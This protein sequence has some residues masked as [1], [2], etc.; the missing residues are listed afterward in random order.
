MRRASLLLLV[1]AVLSPL[2]L[3]SPSSAATVFTLAEAPGQSPNW[4]APLVDC[5]HESYANVQ[6]F[7]QLMYRP[8]Y[9]YG[10]GAAT[11]V[12]PSMSLANTPTLSPSRTTVTFTMKGWRFATR[13]AVTGQNVIFFLNLV[14]STPAA[15]CADTPGRGI[16]D[17]LRSAVAV[18]NKVTLTFSTPV[19]LAWLEGNYLSQITPL[20]LSWSRSA[21]GVSN[22]ATSP[23]GSASAQAS[24]AGVVT[25]LQS[26]STQTSSYTSS[27]WAS[28][29]DG[30]YRLSSFDVHGNATFVPNASYSGE[31]HSHVSALREIATNS[32]GDIEAGLATNSFSWAPLTSADAGAVSRG[33][34]KY[35]LSAAKPWAI[36]FVT[37]NANASTKG[38]E[39][40]QAYIRQAL[41]QA[42]DQSTLLASA[43][44]GYGVVNTAP[45]PRVTPAS[46]AGPLTGATNYNPAAAKALLA[47]HGWALVNGVETCQGS[48]GPGVASGDTLALSMVA[49]SGDASVIAQVPTL[50]SDLGAI[51]VTL[52][53]TYD[54]LSHVLGD[55]GTTSVY[56]LCDTGQ[57]YSF[58][59]QYYPSGETLFASG[60][61][62]NIGGYSDPTMTQLLNAVVAGSGTMAAYASYA[63]SNEPVILLPSPTSLSAISTRLAPVSPKVPVI[64]N[65][66]G[67]FTPEFDIVR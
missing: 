18:G 55:C 54:T 8:L 11:V 37:P 7:Q 9:W 31:V 36:D 32:W 13:Q 41:G 20:P 2:V 3:T 15:W 53:V 34:A 42:I 17:A 22:C 5:A 51:G 14:R 58:L 23:Y 39:M 48:C 21:A 6:Q 24:C 25:Y 49:A 35:R 60:A 66:L 45:L 12:E 1:A 50:V 16:P 47:A 62:T 28:G 43:Y 29:V 61:A 64:T 59:G 44:R 30:P 19:N 26:L 63:A 33:G 56:Q 57:G 10:L 38:A 65:P 52:Q 27:F 46:I 67:A 40:A 4:I